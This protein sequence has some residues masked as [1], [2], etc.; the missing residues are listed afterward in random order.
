M[1]Q[2]S[3]QIIKGYELR[4]R[5]GAGGFGAVYKAFQ[6]TIG[7]E[8][9]IKIILPGFSNRP[10][11]IRRF[12]IEAQVIARLEHLHITPLYDYWRDPDGAYLVMRYLRGGSLR[13]ALKVKPYDIEAAAFT[14]DQI[15]SALSTAHRNDIVHRDIKPGNIL[16]DEDGNAY[17]SDFGIAKNLADLSGDITEAD[18]IVGSL[19]YLSP[20]QARSE[21]VTDRTDIYS[22]GVLIYEMLTGLHPFHHVSSVERLYKHINDPLPRID[23]LDPSVLESI[24][25]VVKKATAKNPDNRYVSVIELAEAFRA[26]AALGQD[27]LSSNALEQLTQREQDILRLLAQGMTNKE[28]AEELFITVATVKWYNQQIYS[29]LNVRSRVQAVARAREYQLLGQRGAE[30]SAQTSISILPDLNNPYKGLRAFQA[31]DRADFFGRER[32]TEKL[33]KCLADS[34]NDER[35]VAVIGPS[36]SGKSSVVRAGLVPA[37]R[38]GALPGSENW[39]VVEMIPGVHPIDTLEVALVKIAGQH[40]ESLHQQLQRDQRGLL[41]AAELVLPDDSS[42]LTLI[43]DQFEEVFTLVDDLT[44]RQK[45]LD[46]IYSAATEPRGRVRIVIT[47]RADFYDRP[48]QYQD[49]GNLLR[50]NMETVLPLSAKELERAIVGPADRI[51]VGFED[52]LVAH[53]V[54]EMTYQTGALPLLQYALAELFEKRNGRVL[55]HDAYQEIGGAVGAL[56]KRAEEVYQELDPDGRETARQMFLRLVTLGDGNRR[57]APAGDSQ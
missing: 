4:E 1:E 37:I 16:L 8:V 2:L 9:A 7:R 6:S 22:L 42:E 32:L 10:E 24:N 23:S 51:R 40:G 29:K 11:F 43:I 34:A 39:F 25:A 31:A 30:D 35:F 49:F 18:A 19:D 14:I 52:G 20:E 47:L 13:E 38:D 3:G 36:G 17:L 55:T 45:F 21:P 12:E 5:V 53:I 15:A 27:A 50:S 46:L 41:R 33:L 28:I 44:L 48:L 54:S 56:A 57:Y 26:A